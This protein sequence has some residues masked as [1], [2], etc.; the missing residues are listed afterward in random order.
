MFKHHQEAIT[1]KHEETLRIHENS[2]MQLISGNTALTNQGLDNLIKEIAGLKQSLE[3]FQ[4]ETK[5]KFNKTNETIFT[6]EKKLFSFKKDIEVIRTTK[7]SWAKDCPKRKNLRNN[8]LEEGENE[9]WDECEER[10]TCFL[11]E[12]LDI[13][14]SNILNAR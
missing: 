3:F 2:I 14:T 11:K 12:K 1:R 10:V 7:S 5:E 8:G 9:T 4:E 6:M 13:D